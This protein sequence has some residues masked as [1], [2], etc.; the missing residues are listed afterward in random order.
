MNQGRAPLSPCHLA[1]LFL[2][3]GLLLAGCR[4]TER[5]VVVY[6]SVDQVYSEPILGAFE[7]SSG[8]RVRAVYDVEAAKTTGLASRLVAEKGTPRADV[9]WNGE[10]VQTLRLKELGLLAS[11]APATATG[12]PDQFVDPDGCWFGIGARA[13]VFLINKNLL[14]PSA[15]PKKLEDFLDG[16][17]PP[18]RIGLAQPLF[19]T[20]ATHAAALFASMGPDKALEF[21]TAVQ[22]RG[23]RVV[24]GNSVVRDM[25]VSGQWMF[26][27]TDSDD[28]LGAL[29]RGAPVAVVA[30]DQDGR[31]TLVVPGTVAMVRGAPHPREAAELVTWLL[32]PET[33]AELI[34]AGSCQ[35]S[36][37]GDGR[38]AA[39]FPRGLKAMSVRLD[40]VRQKL[41]QAQEKMR[42][43]FAR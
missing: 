32:R 21:F 22:A 31:G 17:Y 30:P 12:I 34:R 13:R 19:G 14:E 37:R 36:L 29:Q 5:S 7:R 18:D 27:L 20:T 43:V 8:I 28:A 9:F 6:V 39:M 26:G 16:R 33:E 4:S 11:S 24:D 15:Y 2:S 3:M 41:P 42:E 25:V 23:V 38:S 40:D 1:L 10:F 35:W